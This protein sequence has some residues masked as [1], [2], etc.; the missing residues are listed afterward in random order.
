MGFLSRSRIFGVA[1]CVTLLVVLLGTTAYLYSGLHK[2][3]RFSTQPCAFHAFERSP[4]LQALIAI[5]IPQPV[6]C[7]WIVAESDL[8]AVPEFRSTAPIGRAPPHRV[9]AS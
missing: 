2:H 7:E 1:V 9:K 4:G 8:P 3:D 6:A 5:E